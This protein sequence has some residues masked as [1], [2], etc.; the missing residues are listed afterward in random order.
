MA[1]TEKVTLQGNRQW[2]YTAVPEG[3]LTTDI[4]KLQEIDVPE[5]GPGEV[6][7]RNLYLNIMPGNR[8][9]MMMPDVMQAGRS[10]TSLAVGEVVASND[11]G[12]AQGDIVEAFAP[13]QDFA[14]MP[15]Q[16]LTKRDGGHPVE[17]YMG[18]L[19]Q[20]GYTAYFGFLHAG[21]PRAGETVLVSAAAGGVGSLVVQLAKLSGC[22][23]V[24]IAGGR[25]KCAWLERELGIDATIDYKAGNLDGQLKETCP[26]G[27]DLF[28]DNVGGPV[29]EAALDAMKFGG[30]IILC[31]NASQYDSDQPMVG[32][33][34]VPLTVILKNLTMRGFPYGAYSQLFSEAE[35]NLWKWVQ[36]GRIK[37][38]YHVVEGLEQAPDGL[39]AL[40]NGSNRGMASPRLRTPA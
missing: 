23:V 24:G 20:T 4:F 10:M 35:R 7:F 26:E 18:L 19:G 13:W 34:G 2:L 28:F 25:E 15:A 27:V 30:R 37:P 1:K 36:E 38:F 22:R 29:L 17:H 21:Q 3:K 33:K 5:P 39:V 40:L 32:P 11:P 6:L 16:A 8:A 31:G 12:F 14:L 9:Y